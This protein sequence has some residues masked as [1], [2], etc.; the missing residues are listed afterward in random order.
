MPRERI[1]LGAMSMTMAESSDKPT[2]LIVTSHERTGES[3]GRNFRA[4]GYE[5]LL[6]AHQSSALETL[7]WARPSVLL[8]HR[9]ACDFAKLRKAV[10]AIPIVAMDGPEAYRS[11]DVWVEV[12]SR[13][14]D[15]FVCEYP[16]RELVARVRAVM[17]RHNMVHGSV[18]YT[19]G[20]IY[21]HR[22]RYEA[23]IHGT[24]LDLTRMEF[25]V[26]QVLVQE[27][28]RV[29]AR[30]TLLNRIGK[31]DC[32]TDEHAIDTYIYGLRR[33]IE[34]DPAKPALILTVRGFGYK[35]CDT[36]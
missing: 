4:A 24:L 8:A 13:G 21:L 23:R 20:G 29:F 19:A 28:G 6:T 3:L 31:E 30:R 34:Q 10:F 22:E 9:Q 14:A 12:L 33:K 16:T 25:Q 11:E 17:R 35:L 15:G 1:R 7:R 36:N 5:V 32:D 18:S 2:V 26:L 27:P